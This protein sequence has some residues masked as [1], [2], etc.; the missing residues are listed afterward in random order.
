MISKIVFDLTLKI[1]KKIPVEVLSHINEHIVEKVKV[2]K[3][4]TD[5]ISRIE[6]A[7]EGVNVS[8][9]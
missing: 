1:G 3:K 4:F 5:Y 2:S 9:I 8:K 6:N 7:E